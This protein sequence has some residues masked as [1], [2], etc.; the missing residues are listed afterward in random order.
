MSKPP[1]VSRSDAM[2]QG[3]KRYFTGIPCS[4]GHVSERYT[5]SAKCVECDRR[6]GQENP[7]KV[8]EKNRRW[9]QE[10]PVKVREKNRRW[11]QKNLEEAR[12]SDRRW[13]QKNLEKA[14]EDSRRWG[15]ENPEKVLAAGAKRRAAKIQRTPA[16][17]DQEAIQ[18]IYDTA[19]FLRD[20]GED[21]HV[22]H[23]IPLQG[24]KVS[25]LHVHNNLQIID[26]KE[27]ISKSNKF[28]VAA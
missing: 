14:R 24:E 12:Q 11:R 22:D 27:N 1:Y 25:G 23:I 17:A 15:Q 9:R 5:S 16:W 6:W 4:R 2:R 18:E 10:N 3:L 8:R 20:I 13:R 26:A 7:E 21:V 28:E 19:S